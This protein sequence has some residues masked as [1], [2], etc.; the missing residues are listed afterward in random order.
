MHGLKPKALLGLLM[1]GLVTALIVMAGLGYSG[2]AVACNPVS[3]AY[4]RVLRLVR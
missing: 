2:C 3:A 4:E 1:A